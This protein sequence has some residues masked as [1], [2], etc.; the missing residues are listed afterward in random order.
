[1]DS[2]YSEFL[3]THLPLFSEPTYLLEVDNSLCTTEY[4][5]GLLHFIEYKKIMYATQ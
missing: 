2:S 1:M 5:F 4:K 3:A